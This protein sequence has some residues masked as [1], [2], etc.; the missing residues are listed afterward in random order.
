M[1]FF[2]NLFS[3]SKEKK[4]NP[5]LDTEYLKKNYKN[6]IEYWGGVIE[7]KVKLEDGS[8]FSDN[9]IYN[10]KYL[11]YEKRYIELAMISA[12]KSTKSKV[13]YNATRTTYMFLA[14]F[15]EKVE[16]KLKDNVQDI[17]D[18]IEEMGDNPDPVELANRIASTKD[19]EQGTKVSEALI[20]TQAAY[21]DKFDQLTKK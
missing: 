8:T 12:A 16:D 18:I 7:R 6:L 13:L 21:V 20:K 5:K 10:T 17:T 1:S 11:K 19:A 3:K 14:N 15:N 9:T 4:I 2:K